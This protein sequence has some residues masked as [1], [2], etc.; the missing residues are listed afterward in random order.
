MSPLVEGGRDFVEG[1]RDFVEGGR[2]FEEGGR[3]FEEGGRDFVE[4]GRD[5]VYQS[6]ERTGVVTQSRQNRF[7]LKNGPT[8]FE[9][10]FFTVLLCRM[11]FIFSD[12][13]K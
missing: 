8:Y 6:S 2:D 10:G 9:N 5:L 4:G 3:D 12:F 13:V 11:S 7:R 1:G